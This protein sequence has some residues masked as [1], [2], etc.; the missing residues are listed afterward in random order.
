MVRIGKTVTE[1][2]RPLIRPGPLVDGGEVGIHVAG[3]AAAGGDFLSHGGEF[4][5]R[6]AVR[7]SYRKE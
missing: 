7:W 1:P 3:I 6:L 4:A 5:E 2:S